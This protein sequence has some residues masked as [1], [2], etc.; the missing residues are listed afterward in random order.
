M[1]TEKINTTEE[2][3]KYNEYIIL[4]VSW[5]QFIEGDTDQTRNEASRL[6]R[7]LGG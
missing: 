2:V 6:G 5:S 4:D 7:W 3:Y 1:E